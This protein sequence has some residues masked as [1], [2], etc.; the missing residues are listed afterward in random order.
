MI[1][2]KEY[3]QQNDNFRIR[4][5]GKET[6]EEIDPFGWHI[7]EGMLQDVPEALQGLQVITDG[8]MIKAQI[9]VLELY[10]PRKKYPH[11]YCRSYSPK[12]GV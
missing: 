6:T 5:D 12:V 10:V 3:M 8:W 9:A 7:W 1:T 4:L 2:V 11:L